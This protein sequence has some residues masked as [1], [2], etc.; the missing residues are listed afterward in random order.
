MD[1]TQEQIAALMKLQHIDLE[2][3]RLQ[4]ELD[5]LA[6]KPQI[7][8]VRKKLAALAEKQRSVEAV[9]KDTRGKLVHVE[10]E[11]ADLC[12]KQDEAQNAINRAAGDFR[13]VSAHTKELEGYADRRETLAGEMEELHAKLAQVD[14]LM[15]EIERMQ[16][17]FSA[18]EEELVASYKEQGGKILAAIAQRKPERDALAHAVGQGIMPQFERIAKSKGG[19]ALAYLNE[20]QCNTCRTK[21]D[22]SR[23][24]GLRQ[25]APLTLCP[26][27]GR[28]MVVD[29][30]YN[31]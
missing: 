9:Q 26:A 22:Q 20:D 12:A 8:E 29:K 28:L 21:F 31:G 2:C 30:R 11:D 24:L 6:Q 1:A 4:K 7:L 23:V 19:V 5:G 3:A 13:S 16:A 14:M 27:C 17:A 25:E 18:K 15:Q 10:G